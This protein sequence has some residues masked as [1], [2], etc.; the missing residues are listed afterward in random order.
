M[1]EASAEWTVEQLW[2]AAGRGFEQLF[3]AASSHDVVHAVGGMLALTGVACPDLN[4]GVVWSAADAAAT[5]KTLAAEL[6]SRGLP[7]ILLVSDAAG[8]GLQDA[9]AEDGMIAA[10]R[11]PLMTRGPG[12]I[13]ADPQF[14][15]QRARSP[16]ELA[17]ANRLI[18]AAFGIPVSLVE[19]A[20]GVRLLEADDV[21]VALITDSPEPVGSLQVTAYDGL[22]G[23]WSMATHP[24][25]RRRGVARSGLASVLGGRF[26]DGAALGFLIA[27]E[28]GRPLYDAVGFQVVDWATAWVVPAGDDGSR[29]SHNKSEL[30]ASRIPARD[31]RIEP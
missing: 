6:R 5:A 26:A 8:R 28:G 20:F 11:M 12:P 4:C 31:V 25:Q 13:D 14:T 19:A 21:A 27:T 16:A 9:L 23:I 18:A 10:A 29:A 1:R 30:I 7:G 24:G 2:H 17:S 22:V 15:V 3:Q